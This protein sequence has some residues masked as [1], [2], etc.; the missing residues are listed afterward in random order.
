M[1]L[2]KL[3][4]LSEEEVF[5]FHELLIQRDG[6]LP[7]LRTD[8]SLSSVIQRVYN[9]AQ[10]DT[11]FRDP[12]RLSALLAY[13]IVVG[14]PFNDGNKRTAL[15]A[16]AVML[17]LNKCSQPEPLALAELLVAAAAGDVDQDEFLKRCIA[18]SKK[19]RAA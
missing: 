19:G 6:G 9:H 5:N 12:W 16:G 3:T 2:Q 1:A 18:L 10:Y 4:I 8:G 13:A 17:T 14:H 11:T 15:M 7:G